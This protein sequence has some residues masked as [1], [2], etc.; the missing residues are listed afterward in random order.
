MAAIEENQR[1]LC[2]AGA[3][4]VLSAVEA[5][6]E[7]GMAACANA[8]SD[9]F[10]VVS[11]SIKIMRKVLSKTFRAISRETSAEA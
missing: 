8:Y 10:S 2:K 9:A 3:I 6:V 7:T 5:E 1:L 11:H 4:G